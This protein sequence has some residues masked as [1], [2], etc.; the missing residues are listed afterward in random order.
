MADT[1]YKKITEKIYEKYKKDKENENYFY[2]F[3]IIYKIYL[4]KEYDNDDIDIE[5]IYKSILNEGEEEVF[6][7]DEKEEEINNG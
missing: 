2:L 3:K 1:D 6:E 4:K 5:K 7:D